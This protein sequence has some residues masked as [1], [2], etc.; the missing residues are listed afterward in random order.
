MTGAT[1]AISRVPTID[2]SAGRL[3]FVCNELEELQSIL[4][5]EKVNIISSVFIKNMPLEFIAKF[6]SKLNKNNISDVRFVKATDKNE[7]DFY[8]LVLKDYTNF[9][10]FKITICFINEARKK[11]EVE[12]CHDLK[13]YG[14]KKQFKKIHGNKSSL[15]EYFLYLNRKEQVLL[16]DNDYTLSECGINEEETLELSIGER[17]IG[18]SPLQGGT[19]NT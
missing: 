5:D 3:S 18:L 6:K 11:Y 17:E 9:K 15:T 8:D 7:M 4:N 14:L 13:I 16:C 12:V 19:L 1:E 10:T 2:T